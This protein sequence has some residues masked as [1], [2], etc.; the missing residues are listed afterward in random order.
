MDGGIGCFR[1]LCMCVI[2]VTSV[3]VLA[4]EQMQWLPHSMVMLVTSI[5]ELS[6][7]QFTCNVVWLSSAQPARVV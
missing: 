6:A 4:P 2:I 1:C 7:Q 3:Q 5:A